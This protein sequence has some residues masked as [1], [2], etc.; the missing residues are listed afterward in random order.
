MST[1]TGAVGS[2]EKRNS[3]K[4]D[5]AKILQALRYYLRDGQPVELRV[6]HARTPSYRVPHTV[7]GY[8]DDPE[9]LA[10]AAIGLDGAPGVYITINPVDPALLARARNRAAD[11]DK[12]GTTTQDNNVP[13]RRFLPI[14]FDA[15]RPTGISS[16]DAEHVAA[17][18]RARGAMAWLRETLG[19]PAG[20]ITDSGNGA[21]ITLPIDLPGDD[22]GLVNDCIH[23]IKARFEDD[24]VE[25]DEKVGNAS[26]IL[27]LPGTVSRKGEDDPDRPHRVSEILEAPETLVDVPIEKLRALAAMAP[28]AA[29]KTKASRT[30]AGQWSMNARTG[31]TGDFGGFDLEGWARRCG[32]VLPPPDV[33]KGE[34]GSGLRYVFDTC[35]WN[36]DHTDRSFCIIK[37]DGEGVHAGC[38]HK[39]CAGKDWKDFRAMYDAGWQRPVVQS[40]GAVAA[41]G[42]KSQQQ[43]DRET[44]HASAIPPFKPMPLDC[45]PEA[46]R[47]YI[48]TASNAIGVDPA[49]VAVPLLAALASAIGDSR[50]IRLK[51]GWTEP[52]SI[53]AA[54]IAPSGSMKTPA[55]GAGTE[56]TKH[57]QDNAFRDHARAMSDYAEAKAAHDAEYK[58]KKNAP[59]PPLEPIPMRYLTSDPT[60]EALLNLLCENPRGLLVCKDELAGWI[61]SFNEY[62]GGKGGDLAHWLSIWSAASV[63]IDRKTAGKKTIYVPQP[64]VSVVGT[65]QPGTLAAMLTTELFETGGTARVLFTEPPVRIKQWTEFEIPFGEVARLRA[66]FDELYR[67][68]PHTDDAGARS[69]IELPLSADAKPLWVEWFNNHAERIAAADPHMG[70]ALSKLEAYGARLSLIMQLARAATEGGSDTEVEAESIRCGTTLADWFLYETERVYRGLGEGEA[71]RRVRKLEEYIQ[72]KGGTVTVRNYRRWKNLGGPSGED[73]AVAELQVLVGAGRAKWDVVKGEFGRTSKTL[74]LLGATDKTPDATEATPDNDSEN[75]VPAVLSVV[76]K[77]DIGVGGGV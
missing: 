4:P 18:E 77:R 75:G 27:K 16:T 44:R 56:P 43:T 45:F 22:E 51:H 49:F 33:F 29:I 69:A 7:S 25:V 23:A 3:P 10:N 26:R 46:V 65:I 52:P 72:A 8:F 15:V 59:A 30:E 73:E 57:K 62:K 32:V 24:V 66:V 61:R 5:K 2:T 47:D 31:V 28:K 48:I 60:V 37:F 76:S 64:V 6:L 50:R 54:L 67:L 63:I 38:H 19:F 9:K 14:D 39:G 58:G 55:L 35:P 13:R 11:I 40:L 41:D 20:I 68:Q 21:H 42:F 53:F 34:K 36:P 71:S 12:R 1:M 70:A 74:R 17:I